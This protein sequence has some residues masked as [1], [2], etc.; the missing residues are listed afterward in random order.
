MAGTTLVICMGVGEFE[1]CCQVGAYPGLPLVNW[2][3]CWIPFWNNCLIGWMEARQGVIAVLEC[4]N[5]W[6]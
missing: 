1:G 4:K 3:G 2:G 6:K 5:D